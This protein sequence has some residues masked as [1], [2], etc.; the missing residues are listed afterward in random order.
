MIYK[1]NLE[2]LLYLKESHDFFY[3]KTFN[4]IFSTKK[5]KLY[6]QNH[7]YNLSLFFEEDVV[8]CEFKVN[9]LPKEMLLEAKRL[10]PNSNYVGFSLTQGNE[11][12]KK[13][14]LFLN[15]QL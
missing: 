11:Y 15:S 12:T 6:S 10:L 9:K 8:E 7:L 14:G 3:S 1:V 5:I 2:T 13:V 4:G